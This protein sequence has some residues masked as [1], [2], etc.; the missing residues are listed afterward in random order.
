VPVKKTNF[1]EKNTDRLDFEG[2]IRQAVT[3]A[4]QAGAG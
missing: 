3:T 4:M 2:T 1:F